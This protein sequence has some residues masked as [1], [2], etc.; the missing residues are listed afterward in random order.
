M[1][2]MSTAQEFAN[3]ASFFASYAAAY[4]TGTAINMDG[5]LSSVV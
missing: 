2:R 3:I 5:N 4:I 1:G